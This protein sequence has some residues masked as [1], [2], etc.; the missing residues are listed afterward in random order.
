MNRDILRTQS[1]QSTCMTDQWTNIR[2]DSTQFNSVH[3]TPITCMMHSTTLQFFKQD[4]STVEA[5]D[6]SGVEKALAG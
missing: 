5:G 1:D 4:K 2:A 6:S 3:T